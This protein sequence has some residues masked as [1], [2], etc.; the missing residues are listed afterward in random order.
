MKSKQN[1]YPPKRVLVNPREFTVGEVYYHPTKRSFVL[2]KS[3]YFVD[4]IYGRLSNHWDF[5]KIT[6]GG[7]F[8]ESFSEYGSFLYAA[9]YTKKVIYKN[10][11]YA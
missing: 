3:G 10:I 2:V 1:K 6:R 8:G 9:K 11:R 5:V 7:K 4:P